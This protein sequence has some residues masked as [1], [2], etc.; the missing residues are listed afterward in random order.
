MVVLE[1]VLVTLLLV[2]L[3][4]LNS[5]PAGICVE[6]CDDGVKPLLRNGV[7][8]MAEQ[9]LSV[10][11]QRNRRR[12]VRAESVK[13]RA[14]TAAYACTGESQRRNRTT[15]HQ[16]YDSTRRKRER[17]EHTLSDAETVAVATQH[18]TLALS[19]SSI[20][21][22]TA[23]KKSTNRRVKGLHAVAQKK[24]T[25][26]KKPLAKGSRCCCTVVAMCVDVPRRAACCAADFDK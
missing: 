13:V 2:L 8:L 20:S 18:S 1:F 11:A 23:S 12:L 21:T 15:I 10:A 25:K 3:T 16:R 5:V 6:A 19:L 4:V 7:P 14:T 24:N 26:M 22:S 9:R 17:E